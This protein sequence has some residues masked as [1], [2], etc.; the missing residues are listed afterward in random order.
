MKTHPATTSMSS[1]SFSQSPANLWQRGLSSNLVRLTAWFA[2]QAALGYGCKLSSIVAT[3]HAGLTLVIGLW[4]ALLSRKREHAIY[5]MAYVVGSEVLWRM[6]NAQVFWEFGK[7]AVLAVALATVIRHGLFRHVGLPLTYFVL[8]LPSVVMPLANLNDLA[9]QQTVSFYLSGPLALAVCYWL[10][11]NLQFSRDQVLQGCLFL[12]GPV[13][14][15]A[16]MALFSI[17]QAQEIFFGTSSNLQASGGYGP[18]Q[19]S[20]TLGLGM[21]AALLYAILEKRD[22]WVKG[23]LALIITWLAAQCLMTFSRTGLYLAVLSS[24]VGVMCLLRDQQAR[25]KLI[26]AFVCIGSGLYFVTP[27]LEDFTQGALSK[28]FTNINSTG[29][30]Q[31]VLQELDIWGQHLIF[32]VGPGLSGQYRTGELHGL[33]AH[34]EYSRLLAEHGL[35]GLFAIILLIALGTQSVRH[36]RSP[37]QRALALSLLCWSLLFMLTSA[38]RTAAPAFLFGLTAIQWR[39]EPSTDQ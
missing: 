30:D 22:R 32:G 17:V 2:F 26:V 36:T 23:L 9:L 29:R 24:F 34:T 19:V 8:L 20:A 14:S 31:L 27:V 10:G 16:T 7:Y 37:A 1:L 3:A 5:A 25:L 28:R 38:M 13:V 18:N 39:K 12:L 33:M 35:F 11:S 4:A 21:V 15:I 6:A